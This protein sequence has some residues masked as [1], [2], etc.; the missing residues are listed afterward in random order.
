MFPVARKLEVRLRARGA[1]VAGRGAFLRGEPFAEE[2]AQRGDAGG[3]D[4]NV[5][6]NSVRMVVRFNCLRHDGVLVLT[7]PTTLISPR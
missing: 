2:W 7:I 3:D 6:L 4:D 5:L 1:R